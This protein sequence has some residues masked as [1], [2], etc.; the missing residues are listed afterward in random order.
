VGDLIPA[1]APEERL[2]LAAAWHDLGQRTGSADAMARA[3]DLLLP[4]TASDDAPASSVLLLAY[5]M[6]WL[7]ENDAAEQAY[8]RAIA[9]DPAQPQALNNLAY[10]MVRRSG[11]D[12]VETERLARRAVELSPATPAFYDTLGRALLRQER[13]E[14]ALS[15]FEKAL[16]LDP[17]YAEALAGK[18]LALA[19]LGREREAMEVLRKLE[20]T[21]PTGGPMPP[22]ISEDLELL[23]SRLSTAVD[24]R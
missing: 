15:S 14:Q 3:R 12:T 2:R 6:T 5:T 10:L 22:T 1:D 4:L 19:W 8:R 13:H 24:T 21:R 23:R 20:T 7:G 17:A 18:G 16:E 9:L 11:S